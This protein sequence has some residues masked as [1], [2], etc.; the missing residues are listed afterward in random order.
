MADIVLQGLIPLPAV[1]DDNIV[2]AAG[3]ILQHLGVPGLAALVEEPVA[4][5]AVGIGHLR[6]LGVPGFGLGGHGLDVLAVLVGRED[7]LSGLLGLLHG[8]GLLL[9]GSGDGVAIGVG[10]G[11]RGAGEGDEDAVH[12]VIAVLVL[13][14]VRPDLVVGVGEFSIVVG[15]ELVGQQVVLQAVLIDGGGDG[16]AVHGT[17]VGLIA[18]AVGLGGLLEAVHGVVECLHLLLAQGDARLLSG[19]LGG[20]D[21]LHVLHGYAL[22]VVVP[23][24]GVVIALVLEGGVGVQHPEG[25]GV[26]A[27]LT[28]DKVLIGAVVVVGGLGHTVALAADGDGGLVPLQNAGVVDHQEDCQGHK[29]D[30]QGAVEDVGLACVGSGFGLTGGLGVRGTAGGQLLTLFL[31]S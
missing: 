28:A 7:F 31:F 25:H 26:V 13:A 23:G 17:H 20:V 2:A 18:V 10:L 24:L 27:V 15:G 30:T 8:L 11:L 4:V 9:V 3:L 6:A 14:V 12:Q 5:E 29:K 16:G 19:L 1:E 21:K 22:E